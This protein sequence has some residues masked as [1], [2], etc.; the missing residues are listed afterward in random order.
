MG[1]MHGP[2]PFSLYVSVVF[3]TI[4][5]KEFHTCPCHIII[6]YD[7]ITVEQVFIHTASNRGCLTEKCYHALKDVDMKQNISK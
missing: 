4:K 6:Y 3:V 1:S 2:V 7:L 5:G